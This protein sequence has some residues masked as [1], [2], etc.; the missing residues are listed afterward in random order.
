MAPAVIPANPG[1]RAAVIQCVSQPAVDPAVQHAAIQV[2]RLI[3]VPEEAS[4]LVF[5]GFSMANGRIIPPRHV[6]IGGVFDHRPGWFS[7]EC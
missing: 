6:F 2:Y 5:Q 3:P 4:H 1:L 7:C